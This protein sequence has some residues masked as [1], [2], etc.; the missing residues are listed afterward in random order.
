MPEPDQI[1][2]ALMAVL[3]EQERRCGCGC[4]RG[5][6]ILSPMDLGMI[7][8]GRDQNRY[9]KVIQCLACGKVEVLVDQAQQRLDQVRGYVLPGT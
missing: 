7:Q 4:D 6:R 8:G 3:N 5:I 2:E 9:M 1:R